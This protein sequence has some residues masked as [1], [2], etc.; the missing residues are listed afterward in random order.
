MRGLGPRVDAFVEDKVLERVT[1]AEDRRKVRIRLS[2]KGEKLLGELKRAR[3]QA[4]ARVF[5]PLSDADC[6][7][8]ARILGII[9]SP[10][11]ARRKQ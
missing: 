4:F 7:D 1:D 8:F 2:R 6:R 5:A 9:T 10:R 3:E 11:P